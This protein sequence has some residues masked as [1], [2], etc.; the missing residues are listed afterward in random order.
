MTVKVNQLQQ[1]ENKRIA[2]TILKQLGG[3]RFMAMTGSKPKYCGA[4]DNG[5]SFMMMSLARNASK[6]KWMKITLTVMDTYRME[7]LTEKRTK[8][9]A[10]SFQGYTA[11]D[12]KTVTVAEFNDVYFDQLQELFTQVTGM[13]TSL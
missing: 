13:Y 5:D 11:W 8:D 12:Y 1:N 6:A 4:N 2:G 3:N 7:F 9:H 10:N